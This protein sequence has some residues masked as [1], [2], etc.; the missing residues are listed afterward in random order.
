MFYAGKQ[1]RLSQGDIDD[2]RIAIN[3]TP[4]WNSVDL[5]MRY[6]N[7][8]MQLQAGLRN[9]FDEAYRTH[10]SGVDSMGRSLWMS[11]KLVI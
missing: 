8:K 10:G 6:I 4:S 1:D 5:S 11:V 3:G 9:L 7:K 2:D